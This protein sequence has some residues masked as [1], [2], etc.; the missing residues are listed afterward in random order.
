MAKA[1]LTRIIRQQIESHGWNGIQAAKHLGTAASEVSDLMRGK[2]NRFSQERL[3]IFS[4][5][6]ISQLS[7]GLGLGQNGSRTLASTWS[8]SRR[9]EA[10]VCGVRSSVVK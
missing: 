7:S 4:T 2:I 3:Q 8:W 1:E 9:S 5:G 10:P 6:L